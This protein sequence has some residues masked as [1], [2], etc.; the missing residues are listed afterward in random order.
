LH[1]ILFFKRVSP[2]LIPYQVDAILIKTLFV[3]TPHSSYKLMILFALLTV[4]ALS[5]DN[6]AS[7]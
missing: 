4:S 3:S 5:K 6:L 1:L 7:T 2:A